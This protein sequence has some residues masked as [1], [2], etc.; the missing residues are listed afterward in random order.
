M[1]KYKIGLLRDYVNYLCEQCQKHESKV[2]T[3]EP[4]RIRP[5]HMDGQYILRNIKML[6]NKCHKIINSADQKARGIQ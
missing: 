5:G 3:L 6:C 2:G 4:H 1:N